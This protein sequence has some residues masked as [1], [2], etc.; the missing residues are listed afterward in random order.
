MNFMYP[1]YI[2][3]GNLFCW[4]LTVL[5][6]PFKNLS[7]FLAFMTAGVIAVVVGIFILSPA[8]I[9][10]FGIYA[11]LGVGL[12]LAVSV[13]I[14]MFTPGDLPEVINAIMSLAFGVFIGLLL[15]FF[16]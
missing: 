14:N 13:T 16:I 8:T 4:P 15:A 5:L 7:R 2:F 10:A 9:L 1:V 12:L 6:I 11:Y 3:L